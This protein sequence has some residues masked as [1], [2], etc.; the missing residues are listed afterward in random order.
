SVVTGKNIAFSAGWTTHNGNLS[1]SANQQG[2]ATT[3][4]FIGIDVNNAT[5][6][7]TGSGTIT[8]AGRGGTDASGSQSGV[9]VHGSTGMIKGG[10]TGTA[11][12]VTGSGGGSGTGGHNFGVQVDVSGSAITS[13]GGNVSVTGTG[14]SGSF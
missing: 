9:F 10:N 11:V 3:G 7:S 8:L 6:Q 13:V 5:I 4:N 2:T 14:G 1:F 12:I